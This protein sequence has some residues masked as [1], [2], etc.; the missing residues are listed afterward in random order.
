MTE[1]QKKRFELFLDEI[2]NATRSTVTYI[3]HNFSQNVDVSIQIGLYTLSREYK[4][5]SFNKLSNMQDLI[6][7]LIDLLLD[8]YLKDTF[9]TCTGDNNER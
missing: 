6:D 1:I 9:Y 5:S 7:D 2:R 3:E 8:G 4:Y